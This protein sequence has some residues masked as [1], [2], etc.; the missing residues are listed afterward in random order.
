MFMKKRSKPRIDADGLWAY[1]KYRNMECWNCGR[2][3]I[4]SL[5]KCPHCK[6][7]QEPENLSFNNSNKLQNEKTF[8]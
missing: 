4:D 1:K 5:K 8:N 6:A 2:R 7:E 3:I